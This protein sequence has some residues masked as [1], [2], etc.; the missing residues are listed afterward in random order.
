LLSHLT[1]YASL[2]V[3]EVQL[4]ILGISYVCYISFWTTCLRHIGCFCVDS[5]ENNKL[6]SAQDST[7]H[8]STVH[9]VREDEH[10]KHKHEYKA[11]HCM[12]A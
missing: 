12:D 10:V 1:L 3:L 7:W 5:V 4:S 6:F 2:R 8:I 11:Y 9:T